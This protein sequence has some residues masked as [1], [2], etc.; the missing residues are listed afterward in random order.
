MWIFY[1]CPG[2][3]QQ[4]QAA[5]ELYVQW[6]EKVQDRPIL[7]RTAQEQPELAVAQE[8][9]D[10]AHQGRHHAAKATEWSSR[11]GLLHHL[12]HQGVAQGESKSCLGRVT[13]RH[14]DSWSFLAHSCIILRRLGDPQP[15]RCVSFG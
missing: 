11:R 4:Q 15:E 8:T 10:L 12:E 2:D 6:V 3:V 14:A 9:Q 5:Q 13:C 1:S 7:I